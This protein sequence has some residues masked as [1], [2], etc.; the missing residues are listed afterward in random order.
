M[1]AGRLRDETSLGQLVVERAREMVR[2]DAAVL[3]WFDGGSFRLLASAGT[4]S[5]PS[6]SIDAVKPTAIGDAFKTGQPVIVN[7]YGASGQTTRWGREHHIHSQVAVPLMVEGRAVGALAVLSFSKHTYSD[8]DAVALSLM[9]A[10]VAPALEV[11]RQKN[12]D[13]A[14]IEAQQDIASSEVDFDQLLQVLSE[15]ALTLT[16]ADATAV[17]LPEGSELV[18]KAAAGDSSVRLGHRLPIVGSLAGLAFR[19]GELQMVGNAMSDERVHAPTIQ[20]RGAGGAMVSAPLMADERVIGVL[21]LMSLQPD[22]FDAT[23]MRTLEMFAGFA[24][25]AYQRSAATRRLR[26]VTESAPDPIVVFKTEGEVVDF[27]PAAERTFMRR[28]D[29]VV[30]QN[31]HVLLA[32]KHLPGLH[33]W[34]TAAGAANSHEYAGRSFETT[35]KRGDGSE[36]PMEIAITDLPE[37]TRLV[38]AFIRDLTLRERLRESRS[39]LSSV[40]A[41]A[42]VIVL[43]CSVDG[44]VSLAEGSGL[45]SLDLVPGEAVGRNIQNL[46]HWDDAS[47]AMLDRALR[48]EGV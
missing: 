40:V 48:G 17:L 38:A 7:D 39:L 4:S 18:I 32:P 27:N 6:V 30:G 2:G 43:A 46:A 25:A 23:H 11:N 1:A 16:S 24:A 19:T 21:Q 22:T 5:D 44:V 14:I 45:S 31:V 9:S 47:S 28:R 34:M 13:K 26:A 37:E 10:I 20:A 12:L 29:E 35:G 8:S 41:S 3:R 15:R 42:P 33:R 36:F